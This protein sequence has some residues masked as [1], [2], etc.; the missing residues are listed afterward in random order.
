MKLL[1]D[2]MLG[3]TARYLRLLGIDTAYTDSRYLDLKIDR[4]INED[5]IFI[6]RDS[7]ILKIKSAP[8]FY[9]VNSN[10]PE[11]QLYEILRGLKIDIEEIHPFSR[12]LR[13]NSILERID[14]KDVCERV[15]EYVY[16]HYDSFSICK[17]CNSVYWGGTHYERMK[18]W[19]EAVMKNIS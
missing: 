17:L 19:V 5:R 15:P 1:C 16:S 9:F 11:V 6:T 12:C 10:F 2:S 4:A 14:K 13:C 3:K 8:R 7:R 18:K